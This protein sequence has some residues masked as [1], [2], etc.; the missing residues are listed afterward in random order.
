MNPSLEINFENLNLSSDPKQGNAI[1]N[2]QESDLNLLDKSVSSYDS[3]LSESLSD[4]N[5]I[6]PSFYLLKS[7]KRK[8]WSDF[9]KMP[10]S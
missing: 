4:S 6:D 9:I 8:A 5:E 2:A 1:K 7:P 3:S 10:K